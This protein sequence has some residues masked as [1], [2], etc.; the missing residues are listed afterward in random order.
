MV[1]DWES[2]GGAAIAAS[3]LASGLIDRGHHVVRIVGHPDGA[4]H[5]WET[6]PVELRG[7]GVRVARRLPPTTPPG[8]WL[9]STG[10]HRLRRELVDARADVVNL[11]NLHGMTS[12]GW[13]V[14]LLEAAAPTPTVWTLHDMWSFTGRCAYSGDCRMFIDGCDASCPTPNEYPALAP[15]R[16]SRSWRLRQQLLTR[17]QS[18]TAVAPSRWL[19]REASAGAW[20]SNRVEHI[21]YGVPLD[22]YRQQSS[23][24]LRARLGI[25]GAMPVLLVSAA[26]LGDRRKGADLLTDALNRIG[27]P[28]TVLTMGAGELPAQ[29]PHITVTPVGVLED[30]ESKALVYSAADLLIHPAR[31]DNLPLVVLEAIACGTPVVAFDVGGLSDAVRPTVSGWLVRRVDPGDLARTLLDAI[32]DPDRAGLEHTCRRLAEAEYSQQLEAQHYET[33]FADLITARGV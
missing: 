21:P 5:P 29:L 1:S 3:R 7:L 23:A 19:Q 6:R 12:S 11:H 20:P 2:R 24:T 16:I 15:A 4:D 30:D 32:D 27:R 28:V 26:D 10:R 31:D 25:D 14:R 17:G 22:R 13:T 8:R 9:E 18:V 33:L